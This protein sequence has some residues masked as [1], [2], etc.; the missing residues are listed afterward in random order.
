[1]TRYISGN[2]DVIFPGLGTASP[3]NFSDETVELMLPGILCG[4]LTSR[5]LNPFSANSSEA[6][7]LALA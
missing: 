2:V 6:I 1:M 3:T 7:D 5:S 4:I